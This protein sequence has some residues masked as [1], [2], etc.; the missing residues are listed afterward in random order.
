MLVGFFLLYGCC[1]WKEP[2]VTV[3]KTRI[4][5]IKF[6]PGSKIDYTYEL[7]RKLTR[8]SIVF[9]SYD[10]KVSLKV[11]GYH[12]DTIISSNAHSSSPFGVGYNFKEDADGEYLIDCADQI[13]TIVIIK[14]YP[15]RYNI[16]VS[17][18]SVI[19]VSQEFMY[20]PYE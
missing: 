18:D 12:L 8:S 4:A 15:T 5:R 17:S 1:E 19:N 6:T 7:L 10:P 9:V 3:P 13:F 11:A 16:V 20:A 2:E 14:K